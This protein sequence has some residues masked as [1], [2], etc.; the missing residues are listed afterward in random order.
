[1]TI[2]SLKFIRPY[3][4][5]WLIIEDAESGKQ[6]Y[7]G[8]GDGDEMWDVMDYLRVERFWEE[9]PDEEFEEKYC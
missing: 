2:A 7:S 8:H 5:D 4:G 9:I 3:S 1:M 6:I